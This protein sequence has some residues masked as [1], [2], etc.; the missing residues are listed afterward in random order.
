MPPPLTSS[1]RFCR[2]YQPCT[3]FLPWS[4]RDNSSTGLPIPYCPTILTPISVTPPVLPVPLFSL[5]MGRMCLRQKHITTCIKSVFF[6]VAK[7]LHFLHQPSSRL[8]L[9]LCPN[10]PHLRRHLWSVVNRNSP[11]LKHR[12]PNSFRW[13]L[14]LKPVDN[15]GSANNILLWAE[16]VK[17]ANLVGRP[18]FFCYPSS[19]NKRALAFLV[20]G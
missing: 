13:A 20:A 12:A 8:H 18:W 6:L 15:I 7:I 14:V 4:L 1:P 3:C 16:I 5:S 9:A 2:T 11:L 10:P 19:T 17:E